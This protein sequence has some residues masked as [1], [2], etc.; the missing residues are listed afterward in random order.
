M[1]IAV[2]LA[3]PDRPHP[4]GVMIVGVNPHRE[5]DDGYQAFFEL[6]AAQVVTAINAGALSRADAERDRAWLFA[7]LMQAPVSVCVLT[8]PEFVFSLA[9]PLPC[10]W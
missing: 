6:V 10:R 9:N 2:P 8:G 7:Q 3:S 5:L 1:A 4:Y